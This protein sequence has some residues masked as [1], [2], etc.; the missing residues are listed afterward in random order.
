MTGAGGEAK[1][2]R[3]RTALEALDQLGINRESAAAGPAL[4]FLL[5]RDSPATHGEAQAR[6]RGAVTEPSSL[7]EEPVERAVAWSGLTKDVLLDVVEFGEAG[8]RPTIWHGRLPGSK[9]KR[10][11]VLALIKLALDK[12]AYG[13]DEL[14]AS[15]VNEVCQAYECLDQ[16]LPTNLQRNRIATRRGQRGSY[17][18]R[19]SLAGEDQARQCLQGLIASEQER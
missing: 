17:T 9:S 19:L 13:I 11:R 10:Q 12:F 2:G 8:V 5:G 18:Y 1:L 7:G 16:N 4:E 6:R 14:P 3:L 15:D